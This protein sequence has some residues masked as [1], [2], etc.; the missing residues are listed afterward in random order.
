MASAVASSL[1]VNR[2]VAAAV[3]GG[4][5]RRSVR[6]FLPPSFPFSF[7]APRKRAS[8]SVM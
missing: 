5:N 8:S 4:E 1:S 3:C 6:K 2:A 7:K